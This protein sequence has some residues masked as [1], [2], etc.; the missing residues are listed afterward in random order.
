MKTFE[1]SWNISLGLQDKQKTP[2]FL[3]GD[4][5]QSD[6]HKNIVRLIFFKLE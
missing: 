3:M 5:K 6:M 2:S 1:K 4:L